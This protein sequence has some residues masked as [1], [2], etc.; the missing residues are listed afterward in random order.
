M[1]HYQ[2]TWNSFK[3]LGIPIFLTNPIDRSLKNVAG[4]IRMNF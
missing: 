3:Y 1:F 4:K 2:E